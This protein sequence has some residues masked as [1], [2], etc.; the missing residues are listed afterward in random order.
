MRPSII[1]SAASAAANFWTARRVRKSGSFVLMLPELSSTKTTSTGCATVALEDVVR[2]GLGRVLILDDQAG[3]RKTTSEMLEYLGYHPRS[4]AEGRE[5][6]ELFREAV[7]TRRLFDIALLD[8]TIPGGQGGADTVRELAKLGVSFRAIAMTGYAND[9]IV[10]NY[11]AY[12]FDAVLVK[13]FTV[14]ELDRAL[15]S[16]E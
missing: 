6:V 13:P 1:V 14:L 10:E 9:E 2:G 7:R 12:G 16:T 15:R 3:A 5:A 4:A 8:L 11:A